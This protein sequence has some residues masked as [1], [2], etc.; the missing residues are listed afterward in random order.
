MTR[1]TQTLTATVAVLAVVTTLLGGAIVGGA[2]TDASLT[3]QNNSSSPSDNGMSSGEMMDMQM[4]ENGTIVNENTD[5]LPPGC[6][7]IRGE[8][9]VT[10]RGG[11][12]YSQPGN[13]FAFDKDVIEVDPC[14]KLTVTFINKDSVRHQWMVHG[15]PEETYPSGMF[16]IEVNG[17]ARATGT[18]I[19][20]ANN[21][22]LTTHCSVPQHEQ[23]GMIMAVKVGAGGPP[24]DHA[25]ALPDEAYA[26]T[27]EQE[28]EQFTPGFGVFVA[29]IALVGSGLLLRARH[30]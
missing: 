12:V 3:Q 5:T 18:F 1:T 26:T 11:E 6:E 30:R 15:L 23:K 25:H 4:V 17:P 16:N 14:T 2:T 21:T 7:E 8:K 9:T 13:I 20:P 19:T 10:V 24:G 22:T 29:V 27:P 28:S